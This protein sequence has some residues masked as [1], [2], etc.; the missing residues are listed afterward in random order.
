MARTTNATRKPVYE[1]V[2]RN[3]QKITF[4]SGT[5]S[6]RVRVGSGGE[7]YSQTTSSLKAA[8]AFKAQF[9]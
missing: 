3:I 8:K 1:T 6:Y 2:M 5:V 4:P 9:A 7:L